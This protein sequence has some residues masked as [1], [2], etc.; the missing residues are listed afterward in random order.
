[1]LMKIQGKSF[2][3]LNSKG[4]KI[5]PLNLQVFEVAY[6]GRSALKREWIRKNKQFCSKH[7]FFD[8]GCRHCQNKTGV[9]E[10]A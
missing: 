1:M 5:H 2:K 8:G 6:L 4:Q 3:C 7:I 9:F 10:A